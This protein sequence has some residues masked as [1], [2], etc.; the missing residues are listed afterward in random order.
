MC[1]FLVFLMQIS[2]GDYLPKGEK[3][4]LM[5]ESHPHGPRNG[6]SERRSRYPTD[7]TTKAQVTEVSYKCSYL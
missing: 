5:A 3:F 1:T 7:L 6:I 4:G 2:N